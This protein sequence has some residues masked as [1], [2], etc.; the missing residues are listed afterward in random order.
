MREAGKLLRAAAARGWR[1]LRALSGDDAWEH[2]LRHCR[3]AH[4][5]RPLPDR[6]T[7]EAERLERK[8]SG[9]SRCC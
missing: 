5:D 9:I 2:Y 8:W 6:R 1:L 7:F 4:P 3:Q